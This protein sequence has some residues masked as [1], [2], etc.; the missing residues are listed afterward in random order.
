MPRRP[1]RARLVASVAGFSLYGCAVVRAP[2]YSGV[3]S[4]HR[5]IC[6]ACG[7]RTASSAALPLSALLLRPG[8]RGL[9][10]PLCHLSVYLCTSHP[11][12]LAVPLHQKYTCTYIVRVFLTRMCAGKACTKPQRG[13]A[14]VLLWLLTQRGGEILSLSALNFLHLGLEK[15][16]RIVPGL[17]PIPSEQLAVPFHPLLARKGRGHRPPVGGGKT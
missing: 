12:A 2:G 14:C 1:R 15:E 11:L 10:S 13:L 17:Q 7:A 16:H 3:I 5:W 9:R 8:R 6:A 4:L